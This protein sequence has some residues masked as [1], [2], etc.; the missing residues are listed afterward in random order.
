MM[1]DMEQYVK[2]CERCGI[3]KHTTQIAKAP[4]QKTDVPANAL[5]K[6]QV[7]FL[8]PFSVSNIMAHEYRYA[9][10]IQDVLSRYVMFIPTVRN[11]ANQAAT[12]VFNVYSDSL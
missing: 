9:L 7:D 8:G 6:V 2:N 11:D 5:D 12:A 1:Q 3:N 10:Q 4:N